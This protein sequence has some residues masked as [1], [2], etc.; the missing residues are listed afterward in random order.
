LPETIRLNHP[1]EAVKRMLSILEAVEFKWTVQD[2]LATP[3]EWIDDILTAKGYGETYKRI[4]ED[5]EG[6]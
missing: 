6:E 2:V 3:E 1:L 5:G 4:R